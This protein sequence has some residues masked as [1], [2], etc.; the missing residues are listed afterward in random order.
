M[1]KEKHK[2]TEEEENETEQNLEES[3]NDITDFEDED[4]PRS[5]LKRTEEQMR[6]WHRPSRV[7]RRS[8][9]PNKGTKPSRFREITRLDMRFPRHNTFFLQWYD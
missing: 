3:G 8:G 9:R 6:K 7:V 4:R 1:P 5:S 2:E